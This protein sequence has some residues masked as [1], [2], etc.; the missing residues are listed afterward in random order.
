MTENNKPATDASVDQVGI[1][2][3]D[4]RATVE[5]LHQLLGIGPF[6]VMEFPIEG[7]DPQ[8][9]YY[10][11]PISYKILLG[12]GRFGATQI[13]LVQP[14]EGQSI[15]S[16]FLETHGPGLHHF[17]ITL[18]NFEEKVAQLEAAGLVNMASGAGAH[19]GSKW[20]YFDTTELLGGIL[21]ELRK[22]LDDN[23]GEGQWAAPGIQLGGN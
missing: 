23:R 17:R 5:A 8:T 18:P 9:T 4:L 10:G 11:K 1:V 6:R 14:L 22:R 3:R 13:E 2:V 15:W 21:I 16:D 12:F 20:A 19:I 7:V